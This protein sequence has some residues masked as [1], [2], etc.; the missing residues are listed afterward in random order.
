MA[1]R[2]ASIFHTSTG[3]ALKLE[4]VVVGV[5]GGGEMP[6]NRICIIL[7]R[8]FTVIRFSLFS[9]VKL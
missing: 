8:I 7:L 6:R 9:M 1:L 2:W 5:E 4:G 3:E